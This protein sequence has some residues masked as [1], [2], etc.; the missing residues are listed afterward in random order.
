MDLKLSGK[1]AFITGSGQGIGRG[2]AIELANEGCDVIINDVVKEKA[3]K[4]CNE[5]KD[6]GK[7]SIAVVGDVSK[8]NEINKMFEKIFNEFK[9][10]D[11]LVSC[12]G[13]GDKNLFYNS[14]KEEWDYVLGVCLYGT[15]FCTRAVINKMIERNYG[16]IINIVS[17]AGRVGEPGLCVYSAAKAGI[18]AFSKALA[19][20]LG[21][22]KINV[23]CVSP[24][25][26]KSNHIQEIWKDMEKKIGKEAF[27]ERQKKVLSRYVIRRFGEVSDIA[28]MVTFLSSDISSF[29]TGQTISVSGG[30]SMI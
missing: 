9:Y 17:E 26:T 29:I 19:K 20:E 24:G 25:A 11:I 3:D 4:V 21:R 6:F 16:K 12:A 8:E 7:R 5:I 14:K 30:Y 2:I 1:I 23:N 13:I 10:L 18:I 28:K 22:Y 15:L 27:K